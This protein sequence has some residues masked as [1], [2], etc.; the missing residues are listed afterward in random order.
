MI[1]IQS[2]TAKFQGQ[3]FCFIYFLPQI[4][5]LTCIAS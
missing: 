1:K 3:K 2:I 5:C 4:R